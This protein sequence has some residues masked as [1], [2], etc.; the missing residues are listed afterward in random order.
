M[1]ERIK[2]NFEFPPSMWISD[3]KNLFK[4]EKNSPTDNYTQLHSH[5]RDRRRTRSYWHPRLHFN[6]Q[7]PPRETLY[8]SHHFRKSVKKINACHKLKKN[9]LMRWGREKR[10]SISRRERERCVIVYTIGTMLEQFWF[11]K[12]VARSKRLRSKGL[13]FTRLK[14]M[15]DRFFGRGETRPSRVYRVVLR[16]SDKCFDVC[17]TRREKE[18]EISYA[19][20]RFAPD[21]SSGH[22]SLILNHRWTVFPM[23]RAWIFIFNLTFLKIFRTIVRTIFNETFPSPSN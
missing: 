19:N 18:R 21:A 20:A 22:A 5:E 7:F 8:L 12:W 4:D 11:K 3:K 16:V 23:F 1:L 9:L 14:R 17:R 13:P 6:S 15:V 10:Y 2:I